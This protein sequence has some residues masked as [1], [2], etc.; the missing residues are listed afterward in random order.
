MESKKLN[1]KTK[2]Y[3]INLPEH[4][5]RLELMTKQ[6]EN[7]DIPFEI[8]VGF[9]GE[10]I[11][12][13]EMFIFRRDISCAVTKGEVGCALSH[14]KA[15]RKLIDSNNEV[16]LVIEDDVIIPSNLRN[17]INDIVKRNDK[18]KRLVT[19]LSKVN[20]YINKPVY[21]LSNGQKVFRTIDATF[22]HGYIINRS[23]ARKL[24]EKL[25]PVWC[26]ADQWTLFYQMGFIKLHATIPA[27]LNTHPYFECITT[28]TGRELES[29]KA[30]KK[31]SW[32]EIK[33]STP[34]ICKVKKLLWSVFIKP[35]VKIVKCLPE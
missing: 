21:E 29:T 1:S 6:M 17:I 35:F 22:A 32:L 28:I 15:Y 34:I 19:L 10:K 26:V 16:A 25:L 5:D 3:I 14:L 2:V 4:K 13:E 9:D 33:N 12:D 27:V 18:E 30:C 8:I 20:K 7:L 24:L 23:A 11:K 31:K